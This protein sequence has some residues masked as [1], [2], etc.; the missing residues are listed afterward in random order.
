[1]VIFLE[2]TGK[3]SLK[4]QKVDVLSQASKSSSDRFGGDHS[5]EDLVFNLKH[6]FFTSYNK[7]L[8]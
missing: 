2:K 6:Q 1:M 4:E 8:E 5:A 3:K 7:D